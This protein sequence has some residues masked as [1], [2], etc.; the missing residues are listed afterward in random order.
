MNS[1]NIAY[2]TTPPQIQKGEWGGGGGGGGG[3]VLYACM[4]FILYA[5][6]FYTLESDSF[7]EMSACV[8]V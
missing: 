3:G 1:H 5:V 6:H 7:L 2:N 4:Q 8:V